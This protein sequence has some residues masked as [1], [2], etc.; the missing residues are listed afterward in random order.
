MKGFY[1]SMKT[2]AL[3]VG[4]SAKNRIISIFKL[5]DHVKTTMKVLKFYIREEEDKLT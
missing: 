3:N 2:V 4:S 1:N 5:Y